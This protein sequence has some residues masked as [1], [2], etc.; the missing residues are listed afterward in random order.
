[1]KWNEI[2]SN[3]LLP[4]AQNVIHR[5]HI[6]VESS[7]GRQTV[8]RHTRVLQIEFPLPRRRYVRTVLFCF[9]LS[10][11]ILFCYVSSR[12]DLICFALHC[13]QVA[14]E[15]VISW[16]IDSK[17]TV[18][19][20]IPHTGLLLLVFIGNP[21]ENIQAEDIARAHLCK[22]WYILCSIV[23]DLSLF[24]HM[25]AAIQSNPI[26]LKVERSC[27]QARFSD[28]TTRSVTRVPPSHS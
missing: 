21:A 11:S 17:H 9:V 20:S 4:I 2:K 12:L 6:C 28:C 16:A 27:L 7:R 1:M 24:L 5:C 3:E 23:I 25:I 18:T 15:I 10:C 13:W 26:L 19:S 14:S 8:Y 22:F